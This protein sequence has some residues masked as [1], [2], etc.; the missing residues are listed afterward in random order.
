MLLNELGVQSAQIQLRSA[1]EIKIFG[2]TSITKFMTQE[3]VY[4][5]V[6]VSNLSYA[7][8]VIAPN[9]CDLIESSP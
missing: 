1:S 5:Y 3:R 4:V 9:E 2:R 8:R 7:N 6:I